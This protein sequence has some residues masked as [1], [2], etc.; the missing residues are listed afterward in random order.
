M[1]PG[2]DVT[3]N[4]RNEMTNRSKSESAFLRT[5]WPVLAALL[6]AAAF[7]AAQAQGY[8]PAPGSPIDAIKG[9]I[10]SSNRQAR[11]LEPDDAFQIAVRANDA[12]TLVATLTPA[13]DYYIYRDRISFQI[14]QPPTVAVA[15]VTM[16][17][18]KPKAD[19]T[20]GT[21]EVF[22]QPFDAVVALRRSGTEDSVQLRASYQGCN[23]PLGVCYPPIEKTVTVS[24][25]S[26]GPSPVTDAAAGDGTPD[27]RQ[28]RAL[29]ASSGTWA[30]LA[31][32]FG[33]GVL[34]AFTPCMLPMIPI[35]SGIVVGQG[36]HA[37]R[38][39]VLGL[40]AVYV[41]GMAITYAAA[42]VAAGLAGTLLAAYLQNPWV[43]GAF[44][45]VFVLLALS[46]FGLYELQLPSSLQSRLAG[47]ASRIPGGRMAGAFAMG[48][49]SA[50]I[51]GPCVAAPLAGA[52]LYIGQTRDVVL[53]GSA[54]FAMAVGMGVP[55][56]AVGATAGTLLPKAGPW[57]ESVKRV[58]GVLM[59]AVALYM[60]SPVIPVVMQQLL[61]AALL[62]VP[63][64]YLH[65]LDPLPSGAPG[66]R[67][68]FKG[69]GVLALVM[70][71]ALMVGAL[72]GHR[73]LLQP[74]GGLRT[75]AAQQA[76]TAELPFQPVAS[77]ADLDGRL[78]A[79]RGRPAM[80]DFWAEWCVSCKEMDRFTFSD[81]QVRAR[82]KDVVLLRADVT[83]N[84]S[85]H[86]ALLKRFS[87]FGPPGIIFFDAEGRER[88][89]RVIG[90]QPP[91]QFRASLDR[92]LGVALGAAASQADTPL[93]VSDAW[94]RAT[95]PG[96][97]VAAAYLTLQ[98]TAALRLVS[99]ATPAAASV[100]IHEMRMDREI[101]RMRELK[102][103]ELAAGRPVSLS[104]DGI[105]LMLLDVKQPLRPGQ[106]VPMTFTLE[107][108]AGQRL[109]QTL[110]LAVKA[111]AL[112]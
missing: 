69:V 45:A 60:L 25:L 44:A 26:G 30:L 82:L 106:S 41:L 13:A 95:V 1:P 88:P 21:V 97:P 65:A 110:D 42:G 79:A 56:L 32:F 105:H 68:L 71:V 22:H 81:S 6:L 4:T 98:A 15:G 16:P 104:P 35:L 63:A 20:F 58:F 77:L 8:T 47:A 19:P 10:G 84:N 89:L 111:A 51:V 12:N 66:H 17:K 85:D 36:R 31:A 74:L 102:A 18:G 80:L 96:Q 24:L 23:E 46:M 34:L 100:Q 78:Q 90:Y 91:E 93:R 64:I 49:L 83:A 103:L 57:T 2:G 27:D 86:Q 9:W 101:M 52:L 54:L 73:D 7:G 55:L 33:F 72:S 40:S 59:L 62:I 107:N 109:S 112:K 11:L 43:L 99:V 50:V 92:A 14:V 108:T 67:R 38:R 5:G 94:I 39:H 28:I 48:V 53:G 70:G 76:A 29:F 3:M 61:W 37:T 87:L 75:G